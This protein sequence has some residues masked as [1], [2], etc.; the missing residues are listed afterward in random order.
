MFNVFDYSIGI[1]EI[2]AIVFGLLFFLSH[3][4]WWLFGKYF[5]SAD[6]CSYI[7]KN[8][9]AWLENA[10]KVF[11]GF[12]KTTVFG[13]LS[14][15]LLV[16]IIPLNVT[17]LAQVFDLF[18]PPGEIIT[19]PYLDSYGTFPLLVGLLF[20]L[21]EVA[22]SALAEYRKKFKQKIL[23]IHILLGTM[24]F[25]EAGLN[26]YRS[27]IIVADDTIMHTFWD[28]LIGWGGPFLAGFMG[29]VV[30]LA[31]ILLGVYALLEFIM[32]MIRN[33]TILLRFIV[34]NLFIY[35]VI[36]LFGFHSKR[37]VNIPSTVASMA[38]E[39]EKLKR[40]WVTMVKSMEVAR[41]RHTI[42]KSLF[43]L[44]PLETENE[45][46]ELEERIKRLEKGV[47]DNGY[48]IKE[49]EE[50]LTDK[51]R[52]RG[53]IHEIKS[54]L[55]TFLMDFR[56]HDQQFQRLSTYTLKLQKEYQK[57]ADARSQTVKAYE[58]ALQNTN[59]VEH[60][61][62][63]SNIT[64]F[65]DSIACALRKQNKENS[66]L[67]QNEQNEFFELIDPP[68]HLSKVEKEWAR[69]VAEVSKIIVQKAQSDLVSITND[70]KA[71][72]E[73][74]DAHKTLL[75]SDEIYRRDGR[76][77]KIEKKLIHIETRLTRTEDTIKDNFQELQ[78]QLR[79]FALQLRAIFIWLNLLIPMHKR[80]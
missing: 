13:F 66:L 7:H 67:S 41:E 69:T 53:A 23:H 74:L 6:F 76:L 55:R 78:A 28:K 65:C 4:S 80:I 42:L 72:E 22:F 68:T 14:A 34:S 26:I 15:F 77:E 31:M 2:F 43:P 16:G 79:E 60:F 21:T 1:P 11:K 24:I 44:D 56:S 9:P 62:K 5:P 57:W 10:K 29:V 51:R 8:A 46:M 61:L 64:E 17:I 45:V 3:F 58:T 32:P 39:V 59:V 18:V 54:K 50:M 70:L 48:H 30:P 19:L 35:I 75:N 71:S 20:A 47:S 37:P 36:I 33:I 38:E 73:W 52:L 27:L 12:D 49:N 63:E 40:M 25:I